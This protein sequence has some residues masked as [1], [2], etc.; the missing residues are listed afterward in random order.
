M[1]DTLSE[2]SDNDVKG[3]GDKSGECQLMKQRQRRKPRVLFS[4]AQVNELEKRFYQQRYLSA[5]ERD[6]LSQILKLT[7]TQVKIWFQNRRYKCKRQKQDRNLELQTMPARRVPVSVLVKNDMKIG[8]NMAPPYS[9]PYNVNPF[10]QYPSAAPSYGSSMSHHFQSMSQL[11][12]LGYS[13]I[14]QSHNNQR[15]PSWT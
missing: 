9:A 11:P 5:P 2:H 13:N 15:I 10:A 7:S 12:H 1:N 14:S 8:Q 3:K 4:Q 6:Q